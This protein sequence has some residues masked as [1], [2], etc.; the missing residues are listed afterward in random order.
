[1]AD[2]TNLATLVKIVQYLAKQNKSGITSTSDTARYLTSSNV[3]ELEQRAS[4]IVD[5]MT[6][7]VLS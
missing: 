2:P 5:E 4:E 3:E 7:L 1:M 6:S